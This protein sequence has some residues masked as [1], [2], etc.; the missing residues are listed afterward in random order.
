[1]TLVA[2]SLEGM[3]VMNRQGARARVCTEVRCRGLPYAELRKLLNHNI[4]M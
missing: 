1:M 3:D 2:S 4:H